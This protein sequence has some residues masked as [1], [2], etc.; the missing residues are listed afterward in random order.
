MRC[1][2]R[3]VKDQAKMAPVM[4]LKTLPSMMPAIL[5]SGGVGVILRGKPDWEGRNETGPALSA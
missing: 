1:I 4:T 5:N 3:C 2:G